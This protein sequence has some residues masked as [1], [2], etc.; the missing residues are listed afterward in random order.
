MSVYAINTWVT[1]SGIKVST[2]I[3]EKYILSPSP[4]YTYW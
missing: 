1:L 2:E 4:L 3:M